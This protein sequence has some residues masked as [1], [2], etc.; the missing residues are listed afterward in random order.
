[1]A[2]SAAELGDDELVERVVVVEG[3]HGLGVRVER[4]GL[5]VAATP[6]DFEGALAAVEDGRREVLSVA[7]GVGDPVAGGGVLV[8]AGV[9]DEGPARADWNAEERLQASQA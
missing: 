1:E 3:A 8:Q 7:K 4:D 9:A 2:R 6:V 5:D